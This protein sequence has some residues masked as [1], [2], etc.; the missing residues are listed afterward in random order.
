MP[1]AYILNQIPNSYGA[2]MSLLAEM[3][4]AA[5]WTYRASGDGLAGYNATGKVFTG[6]GTGALGWNNN[7]AWARLQ[8]PGGKREIVLQ[9]NATGA[10]RFK[11]SAVA[12]FTGGAPNATTVPSA[13]DERVLWGAGTDA[14]PAPSAYFGAGNASSTVKHQG[15]A[16]AA[17]PYGFWWAAA[18]T[19]GGTMSSGLM[20]DPVNSVPEDPDPVVWHIA[21]AGAFATRL[22]SQSAMDANCWPTPGGATEGNYCYLD[23]GKTVFHSVHAAGY[24]CGWAQGGA[25][26]NTWV[27]NFSSVGLGLNL[28]NAQHDTLPI[29]YAR[30][31]A[32]SMT[33]LGM[34]GWSTLM[35]WTTMA[36]VNFADTLG[37]RQWICVGW[38]W[39]PWDGVTAPT[40]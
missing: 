23:A 4:A 20:L 7:R 5:G 39:L 27:W 33:L 35:R 14:S 26:G 2:A 3:L 24:S 36:R 40:A 8:D 18:N 17:A 19:G 9:H 29:V 34:K 28:F 37:N 38:V 15:A 10:L 16:M 11:Y 22:G 32:P 13:T 30:C 31:N 12:K 21:A 1:N 6:T 25:M